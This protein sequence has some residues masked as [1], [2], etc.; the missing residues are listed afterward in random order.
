MKVYNDIL[1][2]Y[3]EVPSDPRI[4]SLAPSNTDIL[5]Q[6]GLWENLVGIS[7]YCNVPVNMTGKP[8]VGSYINVDYKRLDELK[9]DIIFTTTGVQKKLSIELWKK[10]YPVYPIPLPLSI[11]GILENTVV[12]GSILNRVEKAYEK[13]QL[14]LEMI[15]EL[16]KPEKRVGVYY[17]VELGGP[18][19]VGSLSYINSSLHMLGLRNIFGDEPMSY[20]KPDPDKVAAM[21][22]DLIIYEVNR[23]ETVD[24]D[25]ALDMFLNRGWGNVKGVRE[26]KI[27]VLPRD[28]LAHYGLS[29]FTTLR[30]IAYKLTEIL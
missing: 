25:V 26:R 30:D 7:T 15:E 9:P 17:E 20:F 28:S 14:Y 19:T 6:L 27:L 1:D 29:H 3:L 18:I 4:V 12:I 2:V 13:T 5:Y 23:K 10:G 8:R 24:V 21:N 16:P 11:Y 22:P